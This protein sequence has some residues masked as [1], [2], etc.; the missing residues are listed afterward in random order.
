M[1]VQAFVNSQR[2]LSKIRKEA[3]DHKK[4]LREASA[5]AKDD[6]M[7]SMDAAGVTSIKTGESE[8]FVIVETKKLVKLSPELI[9]EII[10]NVTNEE[11][12]HVMQGTDMTLIEAMRK[13]VCNKVATATDED[14][15]PKRNF[16][17]QNHCPRNFVHLPDDS[18]DIVNDAVAAFKNAEIDRKAYAGR[19]K[20]LMDEATATH[21]AATDIAVFDFVSSTN[22]G[23]L[24]VA[25]GH[26]TDDG[27]VRF[28]SAPIRLAE[29]EEPPEGPLYIKAERKYKPRK[30]PKKKFIGLVDQS[31]HTI[32][33]RRFG[34]ASTLTE[35]RVGEVV[36]TSDQVVECLT[37]LMNQ[38]SPP[39]ET[40]KISLT[41]KRPRV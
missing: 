15:E 38:S 17:I 34:D 24:E 10:C 5:L 8:W 33:S 20:E 25:G 37:D 16:R 28:R 19:V 18:V 26:F 3:K 36:H 40:T 35:E 41:N 13:Y 31:L 7:D 21:N 30:M 6:L 1:D 14:D 4:E 9:T 27:G 11:L 39:E 29:D 12:R 23:E 22:V 2:T 32:L